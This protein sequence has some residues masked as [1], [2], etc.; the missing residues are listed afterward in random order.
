MDGESVPAFFAR[1]WKLH[2]SVNWGW[3]ENRQIV[4][5]G[6]AVTGGIAAAIYPS[7]AKYE[8]SRR[9]PFVVLHD[10]FRRSL[11]LPETLVLITGYSFSDQHLN[12]LVFDAAARRERSEFVAFCYSK[13]PD[14]LST[15]ATTTPNLQVVAG[16][17]AIIGG[18]RGKWTHPEN[19]PPNVWENDKFLLCDFRNLAAYLARSAAGEPKSDATKKRE[20]PGDVDVKAG[21]KV[22]A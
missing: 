10:R 19:P 2:G 22:D 14:A 11:Q 7:D 15:I 5:L 6:R 1:L 18:V 13:I 17:E 9:V 8:E 3:G 16:S 20:P 12:D 21:T 4:R